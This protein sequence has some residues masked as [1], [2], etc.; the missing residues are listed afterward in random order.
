MPRMVKTQMN[1]TG[2]KSFDP[3]EENR[4]LVEDAASIGI[5]HE[6]IAKLMY[7]SVNTLK[8]HFEPELMLGALKANIDVGRSL[9]NEAINGNVSA[10]IWWTKNRMGWRDV[11]R[12]EH[13]GKDGGP[14]QTTERSNLLDKLGIGAI[15]YDQQKD[16]NNTI[17]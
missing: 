12:T 10:I 16:Q 6:D 9:Y 15:V 2:R 7:C 13:T 4:L 14:I 5:T 3:S 8:K 1:G 17:Q 11:Q